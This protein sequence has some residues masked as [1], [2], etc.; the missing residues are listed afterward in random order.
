MNI[1]A[2]PV[3]YF[4]NFLNG[5]VK[6][7]RWLR[8]TFWCG[9]V[10]AGVC[11]GGP[12]R[13]AATFTASLDRDTLALGESATLSLTFEDG[14]PKDVPL[15]PSVSGLQINYVGQS[16]QFIG[17][18]NGQ[19]KSTVTHNFTLTPQQTGEFD[20]PSL[21]AEVNG[22][23]LSSEP[24]KLTVRP[25]NTPPPSAINSGSEIAFMKLT[26]PKKEVY[27]GEV[28]A[29]ELRIYL[30]DDV[31]NFANF[32]FISTPAA[33]FTVG[34][35]AQQSV[36]RAQ[37]GNHIYSVVPLSVPLTVVKGGAA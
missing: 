10:W 12:R 35:M 17:S 34:K 31:Q 15:P 11:P 29:A 28:V 22:Q 16:S 27:V 21:A 36:Q 14:S 37:L 1:F 3:V 20:I 18:I 8:N 9:V 2:L 4:H 26:L 5:F 23:R 6:M 24:L 25:P 32:Q 33:G 13:H 7:E 30:R 19:T